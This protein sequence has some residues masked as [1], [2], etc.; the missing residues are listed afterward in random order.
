[1]IKRLVVLESESKTFRNRVN[2]W[3]GVFQITFAIQAVI[4]APYV[5]DFI[6]AARWE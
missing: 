3:L 4:A 5:F 1:M 2:F 6:I